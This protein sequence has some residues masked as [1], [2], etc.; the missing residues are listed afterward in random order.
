[1]SAAAETSQGIRAYGQVLRLPGARWFVAAG[2]LARFP[3][4]TLSLGIILLVSAA[5]DSFGAAGMAA[6]APA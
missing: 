4:A 6:A 3:R 5:T 2:I 1:M